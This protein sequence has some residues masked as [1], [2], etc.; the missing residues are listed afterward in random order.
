MGGI[1]AFLL[2]DML[3]EEECNFIIEA[4]QDVVS[5]E[6]RHSVP[7][8]L[9]VDLGGG[10]DVGSRLIGS[11]GQVKRTS[12]GE[13]YNRKDRC[14][15]GSEELAT[16]LWHRLEPFLY[17]CIG[18]GVE[19]LPKTEVEK[20]EVDANCFVDPEAHLC[21]RL[22]SAWHSANLLPKRLAA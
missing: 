9:L 3:S 5:N 7:S 4:V 20:Q 2:H 19:I 13:G 16:V 17:E 8:S 10:G 22:A 18:D 6:P 12:K 11:L 14:L 1:S 21:H 15:F